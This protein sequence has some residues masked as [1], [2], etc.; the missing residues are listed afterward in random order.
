[1]EKGFWHKGSEAKKI[2]FKNLDQNC[3]LTEVFI[4]F[5]LEI[6]VEDTFVGCFISV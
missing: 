1:M 5:S 3:N 4:D 2:K 6:G